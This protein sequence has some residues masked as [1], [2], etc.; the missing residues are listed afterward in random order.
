[1]SILSTPSAGIAGAT[2][3]LSCLR[4]YPPLHSLAYSLFFLLR[5]LSTYPPLS[6]A[7]VEL[8]P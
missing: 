4:P 1:M 3:T 2:T 6:R 7:T 5:Y 8:S